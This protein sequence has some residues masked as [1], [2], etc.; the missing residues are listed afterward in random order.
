MYLGSGLSSLS[1]VIATRVGWRACA[2]LV[3]AAGVFP[4]ALM[5][6]TVR[7]V[8]GPALSLPLGDEA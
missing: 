7:E 6:L 8:T 5:L 2:Y 1:I 3:G 4:V